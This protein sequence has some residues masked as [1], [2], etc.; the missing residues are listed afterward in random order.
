[1]IPVETSLNHLQIGQS[2]IVES[3]TVGV[4]WE[5]T[6]KGKIGEFKCPLICLLKPNINYYT[7]RFI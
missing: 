6:G 3:P 7:R 1:M 2:S 5:N 4:R